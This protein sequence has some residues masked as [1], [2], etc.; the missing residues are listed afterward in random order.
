MISQ[1]AREGFDHLLTRALR[2][3]LTVSEEQ[4]CDI[5]VIP[6][7]D[8]AESSTMVVLTVSS[9]LFRLIVMLHFSSDQ[10]TRDHVAGVNKIAPEEMSEQSFHDAIAECGNICC[11]ILNRDLGPIFPHIGMSTPNMIDTRCAAYLDMLDGGH[12]QHFEVNIEQA[13]MFR[14]SLCV[15]DYADLDFVIDVDDAGAE[16]GEL[17]LF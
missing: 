7:L 9:Y 5:N 2:A 13:P 10:G 8:L 12:I 17:E 6:G 3:S 16:T 15:C 11:G 4:A 1:S 14:V